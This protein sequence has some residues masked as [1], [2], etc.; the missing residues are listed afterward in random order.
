MKVH[1]EKN[2]SKNPFTTSLNHLITT[3]DSSATLS[4]ET[5]KKSKGQIVEVK[6][7][8]VGGLHKLVRN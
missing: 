6:S 2:Q 7:V 1:T 8:F 3:C 4:Q 5:L